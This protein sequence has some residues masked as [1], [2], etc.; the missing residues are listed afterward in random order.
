MQTT[1]YLQSPS[2]NIY[3]DHRGED[4]GIRLLNISGY[5][6][7]SQTQDVMKSRWCVKCEK[8]IKSVA[9]VILQNLRF[10]YKNAWKESGK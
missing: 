2:L 10:L 1:P 4:N 6:V 9:T 7:L 8:N 5:Y 3:R